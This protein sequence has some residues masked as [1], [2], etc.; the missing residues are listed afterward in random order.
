VIL[1]FLDLADFLDA[2]VDQ[3]GDRVCNLFVFIIRAHFWE[4][5]FEINDVPGYTWIGPREWGFLWCNTYELLSMLHFFLE[6]ERLRI[7]T[8]YIFG[9]WALLKFK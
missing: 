4:M 2:V 7:D 9:S 1:E 3:Q 6:Q 5:S 8:Q